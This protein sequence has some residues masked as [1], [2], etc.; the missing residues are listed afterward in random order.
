[1]LKPIMNTAGILVYLYKNMYVHFSPLL[2][3]IFAIPTNSRNFTVNLSTEEK[4]K[5]LAKI[6]RGVK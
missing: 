2:N 1:M 6:K 3:R 4:V 5:I